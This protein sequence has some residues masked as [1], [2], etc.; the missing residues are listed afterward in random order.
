MANKKNR[1]QCEACEEKFSSRT[2][3]TVRKLFRCTTKQCADSFSFNYN[4]I[5]Q[6]PPAQASSFFTSVLSFFSYTTIFE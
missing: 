5:S 6:V 1:M 4:S 2:A 3:G